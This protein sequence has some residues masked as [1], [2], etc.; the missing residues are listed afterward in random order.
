ML[1]VLWEVSIIFCEQ[2]YETISEQSSDLVRLMDP[3]PV[4]CFYGINIVAS[5]T[6][7]GG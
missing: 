6:N 4:L 2:I 1:K 3:C 5:S 7:N